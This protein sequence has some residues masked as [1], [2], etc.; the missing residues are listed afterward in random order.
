MNLFSQRKEKSN[1]ELIEQ[2]LLEKYNQY[3]QLAYQYT[4]S[5]TDAFDIV[6][7]GACKAIECSHMLKKPEYA[8]TWIYR[9][10]LNECFRYLKQPM[11]LSYEVMQEKNELK[12]MTEDRYMDVDLHKALNTLSNKDRAVIILKYFEDMKI[13]E[14]AR[15]L[16][17]NENTIK[18][19]L[20]RSIK[21]L[22]VLL[23]DEK[24]ERNGEVNEG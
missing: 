19:R 3:Y 16:R 23:S 12:D 6:Q 14:V 7:T 9:I 21:K 1:R 4:H 15:V 5:E 10:M 17:E 18:S 13:S 11:Y 2:I 20:Y 8:G 24:V 22:N